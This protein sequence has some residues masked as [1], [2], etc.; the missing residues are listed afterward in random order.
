[1]INSFFTKSGSDAARRQLLS[2][3]KWFTFSFL[4][5]WGQCRAAAGWVRDPAAEAAS[6]TSRPLAGSRCPGLG[7]H[8]RQP[9]PQEGM[10]P[11]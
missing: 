11:G 4:F 5:R 1:M 3:G 2:M 6:A 7:C 9:A 8:Q 10:L